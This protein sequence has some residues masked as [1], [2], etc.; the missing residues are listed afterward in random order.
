L[1]S[2]LPPQAKAK[3]QEYLDAGALE[4]RIKKLEEFLSLVPKHKATEKIVALNKSRLAKMKRELDDRKQK[5][6]STQK[7]ISPFSIKKEGIQVILISS[8]QT[9]G[10]G[11]TSLLNYLTGAAENK[12]G[13]FTALP[14][15]GI[16]QYQKIRFQIVEMPSLMEGA[17][18]GVGNGKEILSQL[19]AADLLCI[20]ID[21]SRNI[22]EQMNLL[23]KELSKADI[24]INILPPPLSIEKTGANKIQ[25]L[26][27]TE[28][29]KEIKNLEELTEQIK[30][31]V[32]ENGIRN[33]IVK[34]YGEISLDNVIDVLTPS[35]VYK[36]V[37][38]LGTKGDLPYTQ[39]IFEKLKDEYS[40]KFPVI[41]GTSVQKEN[42]PKDF[43][44]II[45]K[46]LKKIRIY[47]MSG[48]IVAE[49]PLIMDETPTVKD[50]ALKIHRSFLDSFD[51]ALIIREGE[52]QK[53]KK[54]GPDYILKDNDI[55]EIHMT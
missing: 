47:T 34:I 23:L 44:E 46:F 53:R 29:A 42:F 28:E 18:E 8:F 25:V 12:V 30:E 50:V 52:R 3:Y 11:K 24:R 48:G 6:K 41:F 22:E 35:V 32:Y 33:G 17:S 13:K 31:I 55:V 43:G 14:E 49:Q 20:C 54:V 45:L 4:E 15:I 27:L 21:L 37:I 38:I 40:D 16:Y 39:E 19:R 2:N 26:Y 9:P 10:V 36:K 5:Q 7:I 51:H 1:S